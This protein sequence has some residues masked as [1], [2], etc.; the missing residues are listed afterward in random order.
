MRGDCS[1]SIRIAA[2]TTPLPANAVSFK[3]HSLV[4]AGEHGRIL[5]PSFALWVG[6]VLAIVV[7]IGAIYGGG[8]EFPPPNPLGWI[9]S[10]IGLFFIALGIAGFVLGG[11]RVEFDR[12]AGIVRFRRNRW[13]ATARPL[14]DILAVQLI[15]GGWH[16]TSNGL[17]QFLS[18]QLNLVLNDR[19][20]PRGQLD[21]SF[22][23]RRHLGRRFAVRGISRSAIL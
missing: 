5:R 14:S 7:G 9:F 4:L 16:S 21:E 10:E 2:D 12:D 17:G 13:S 8:T 19:D 1:E 3:S 23:M 11:P 22:K 18:Y 15:R 20:E 6:A